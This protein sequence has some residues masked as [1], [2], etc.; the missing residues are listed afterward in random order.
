MDST[1]ADAPPMIA[2]T[3]IQNT[4]PA[5]PAQIAV[6]TP[7]MLPVPTRDAVESSELQGEKTLYLQIIFRERE[8]H[9][10]TIA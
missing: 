8:V 1:N 3:H 7:M 10:P 9:L 2:V 6:A 4:A 5:P